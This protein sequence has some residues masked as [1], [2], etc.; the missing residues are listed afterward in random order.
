MPKLKADC[1][2]GNGLWMALF[3]QTDKKK[4][5]KDKTFARIYMGGGRQSKTYVWET[6]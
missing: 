5:Q 6:V 1:L 3:S 2:L 4:V